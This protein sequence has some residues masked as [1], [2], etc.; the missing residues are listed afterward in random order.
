MD[1]LIQLLYIY[2]YVYIHIYTHI[3]TYIHIYIYVICIHID[4]AKMQK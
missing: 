2:T 1:P 4:P 3:C